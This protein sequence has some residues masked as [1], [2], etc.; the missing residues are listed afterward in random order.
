MLD[1]IKHAM[2]FAKRKS[3]SIALFF[4]DLDKFKQV[5]DSLGHDNGD[6][7]LQEISKRLKEVLRVD[8]TVARLGGDEFVILLE[9]YRS[10]SQLAQIAQ[11]VINE[12]ELPIFL[13]QTQVSVGASI[14][15]AI[16]PEDASD[17][18]E[19][20]RNA[21]VAMYHA[22]QIGRNTFQFFTQRMNYEASIRL[23]K[24]S[25]IKLAHKNNEFINYYQ[26]I[27]NAA[28]N[29]V[30]GLELLLRWQTPEGIK[31]PAEFISFAEELNLI[32]EMT[33]QALIRGLKD[34][35]E[36][37]RIDKALYISVNISAQQ[38]IK[39]ELVD[40]IGEQ[41]KKYDTPASC[42]KL[43][44][45]ES[46]LISEPKKAINTMQQLNQLGVELSLDD[47]GTGYSSL[48]YLKQLPLSVLKIDRSFVSGIG[49]ETM[50]EA[51]VDT[52]LVLAN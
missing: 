29:K 48:S 42:L 25:Q 32:G 2:D 5:N 31:S 47:F 38:F 20:L 6:L 49:M 40:F 39:S 51:I 21:D 24:E 9:S 36:W 26:P 28:E 46:T 34:L 16:Y 10:N 12:I 18:G 35:Q 13:K 1:R 27:I 22:K 7:L 44:I 50:D 15:I 37:R 3:G 23:E 4:I 11:K 30:V 41:L 8:D 43:E 33:E 45:T 14:G 17:S 19:L 52:T